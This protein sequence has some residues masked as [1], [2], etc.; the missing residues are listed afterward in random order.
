MMP[1]SRSIPGSPPGPRSL[2]ILGLVVV[3]LLFPGSCAADPLL[4]TAKNASATEFHQDL[5][6]TGDLTRDDANLV[7]EMWAGCLN[8][9]GPLVQAIGEG[10]FAAAENGVQQFL[11]SGQNLQDLVVQ[12]DIADTDVATFQSDNQANARSLQDLLNQTREYDELHDA[13]VRFR[14]QKNISGLK[15]VELRGEDL[16]SRMWTNFRDYSARADRIVKLSQNFGLATSAFERSVVDFE[17]IMT[18]IDAVQDT[19]SSSIQELI[20]E[21]QRSE[22]SPGAGA[23]VSLINLTILPDRGVYGDTI[24]MAGTVPA[25][26]GTNVTVFVDGQQL[27]TVATGADGRFSFPYRI[28]RVE[29]RTHNAYAL[30]DSTISTVENF[31]V[32]TDNSTVSLAA[33]LVD[34]NGL[35]KAVGTGRLVTEKGVPVRG[36]RVYMDVDG[37]TSW[38]YGT[39]GE[40]GTFTVTSDQLTPKV[41]ALKARFDPVGLPLNSSESSPVPLEVPSHFDWLA[42]LIYLL[43]VGGAAIGGVMFLRNRRTTEDSP[44]V[45]PVET[46]PEP[47]V[48]TVQVPTPEEARAI[49]DLV[50]VTNDGEIDGYETVAQFYRRIVQELEM[51]NPDLRLRSR[52][53]RDLAALFEEEPFGADLSLLVGIHEKVRYS[54]YESTKE[55]LDLAREAFIHVITEGGRH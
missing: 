10:E 16:R 18:E 19:R 29:P 36:A 26:E 21:I 6:V 25:P 45:D 40:D 46:T 54:E 50:I 35:R 52:T 2:I 42:S 41:H 24:S 51:K 3:L 37:R 32:E 55:D 53:P 47:L 17:A 39:T 12:L 7:L 5:V 23:P 44:S 27:G 13:E 22:P 34:A 9:T 8:L 15:S 49:A 14:E 28:E 48:E 1:V 20:R 43:G 31:T 38:E 33:R 4:Y 11:W 30:V